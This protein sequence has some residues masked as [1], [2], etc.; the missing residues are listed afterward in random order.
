MTGTAR[1]SGR[2]NFH[3]DGKQTGH[4]LLD[5]W[6]W[7]DSELLSNTLR[8]RLAEYLVAV[9]LGIANEVRSEWIAYDLDQPF[10]HQ[11]RG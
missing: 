3:R 11:G 2:E 10:R 5:F 9:D 8:G 6:S 1:L 4:R 7:A